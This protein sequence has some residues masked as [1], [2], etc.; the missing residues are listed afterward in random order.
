MIYL[1]P[2]VADNVARESEGAPCLCKGYADRQYEEPT[3][4]EIKAHDCGRGWS[5]CTA[6]FKCRLCGMRFVGKLDAPEMG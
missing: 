2:Y 5:C 3:A 1:N 4:E 6:V